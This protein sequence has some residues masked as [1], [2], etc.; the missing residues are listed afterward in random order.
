MRK[1]A[2]FIVVAIVLASLPAYAQKTVEEIVARVNSDI[3][4]KSELDRALKDLRD[5][6]TQ[7]G[8]Q[9]PRLEQEYDARA[10]DQLR[11]LI[12][13]TLLL[14]VAKDQGLSADIEV[15]KTMEKMRQEYKFDS[16][17]ALER[18]I[19]QQGGDVDDF[20]NNIK[21]RY[22]TSQ[23]IGREVRVIVTTE[24]VREYYE[25]HKQEFDRPAGV[26]LEEISVAT[27]GKKPEEVAEQR[28]KIED[29]L[30]AARGGENFNDL[31]AKVSESQSAQD[32]G[33]LGFFEKGQLAKELE[34]AV[35]PLAKG[36]IS[37]VLTRPDGF[38]ILRV[39]D[40]HNGGLLSFELAQG[41]ISNKLYSQRQGPKIREYLTKL[42][43][44]GFIEVREGYVDTGAAPKKSVQN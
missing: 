6:L 42:R 13:Q 10:K 9:G 11:D 12:D 33:S 27:A 44:G 28:K 14:Q 40:K 5:G 29:A 24:E 7:Q 41:E 30:A 21:T 22:L 3:I 25:A 34:D 1:L 18:A 17:D 23:V 43:T 2:S 15:I 36:Q 16:L 8:L 31:A 35:A 37:D 39:A 20:K 38:M 19:V 4:L 32:G 26:Q